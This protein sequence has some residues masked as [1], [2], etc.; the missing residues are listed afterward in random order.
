MEALCTPAKP[1]RKAGGSAALTFSGR[2]LYAAA[3]WALR[4]A[5]ARHR[6]RVE[7]TTSESA[8]A[9]WRKREL[10]P[11]LTDHFDVARIR[12]RR[13]VDFACGA[14]ELSLVL[15]AHGAAHVTGVDVSA[16]AIARAE[17]GLADA[18]P[19]LANRVDFRV[20]DPQRIP[21]ESDA[22]DVLCCFDALEHLADVESVT[23]EWHRVLRPEGRV[24][25][26]WSPWR[27]PY[28]HHLDSL[29]PLPWI[30]LLFSERTTFSVCAEIYDD[31]GFIPRKWDIDPHSGA[32][33]PN[34]WRH[35]TS[36]APFL[37]R[38]TRGQFEQ[39]L[40]GEGLDILR[41]VVHGFSG[42][43][44]RRGT[45]WLLPIPGVGECF[46]SYYVYELAKRALT[47]R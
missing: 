10:T 47:S 12:G 5:T 16:D 2:L 39:A 19:I 23:R 37:N 33:K 22:V 35:T 25:I 46:V 34:K 26:W 9:A 38:L 18:N 13:I 24:W 36:F 45:R 1:F 27:G 8:Y 11:Q 21:L 20:S 3:R 30:H 43:P 17:A 28:G 32:K 15:A 4:R 31:P 41:R 42:S 7:R 6:E 44:L 29:I 40:H 14:G